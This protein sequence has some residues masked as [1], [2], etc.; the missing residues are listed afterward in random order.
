MPDRP[1]ALLRSKLP[2]SPPQLAQC[3]ADIPSSLIKL[4][5][6]RVTADGSPPVKDD[7]YF[8]GRGRKFSIQLEGRFLERPGV[9]PYTADE[10]I[11]LSLLVNL[12]KG[13]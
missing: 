10:V 7:P 9:A 4:L 11:P 1:P 2:L 5:V 13:E 8:D 6:G 3:S 12:T